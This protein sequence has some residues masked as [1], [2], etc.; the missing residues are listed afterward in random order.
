MEIRKTDVVNGSTVP[1]LLA[2]AMLFGHE[3]RSASGKH[4]MSHVV[5][6][7]YLSSS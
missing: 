4:V 7:K 1:V 3:E 2:S 6:Y 5:V